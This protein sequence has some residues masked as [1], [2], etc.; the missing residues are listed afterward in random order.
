[1]H[2]EL[3]WAVADG[4]RQFEALF[5]CD[6]RRMEPVDPYELA[7]EDGGTTDEA[8]VG[9]FGRDRDEPEPELD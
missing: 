4:P 6:A 9:E 5:R 2:D 1:M 8:Q 7:D 3:I